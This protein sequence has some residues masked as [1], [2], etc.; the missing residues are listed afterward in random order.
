MKIYALRCRR[1]GRWAAAAGAL[2]LLAGC[3]GGKG[4]AAS[5]TPSP[6]AAATSAAGRVLKV[7]S[8]YA[9][10]QK[11]VDAARPGDMVLIAPGTYH[12]AV[13][14]GDEHPRIVIRGADRNRVILDGRDAKPNGISVYA[15]GVAVENLTVRH[16]QVNGVV[17]AADD[18]Y[19]ANAQFVQGWRGSYLTAYDNGL[20]ELYAF[21]AQ[22]GQFDHVYASGGPDSGIY[23]GRCKPCD[24]VVRDSVAEANHVGYEATNASGGLTVVGNVFRDNRV[25]V[26]INSLNKERGAPQ[27]GSLLVGNLV[28]DNQNAHAP[29]GSTG[30]GAGVVIDGGRGNTVR[31]N[32][33]EGNEGVGVIVL[34]SQDFAAQGNTIERNALRRNGT[35]L[36]LEPGAD[37]S[38]GN[39]FRD[40]DFTTS[41]PRDVEARTSCGRSRALTAAPLKLPTAPPQVD[42]RRVPAPPAQPSMPDAATAPAAPAVGL[43]ETVDLSHVTPPRAGR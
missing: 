18:A 14:V 15:D 35:D 19:A 42:Y 32:R 12:E 43:P 22:H 31:E 27:T 10:I 28:A 21:G 3:G 1:A 11:A 24:A 26:Q 23:V 13:T 41:V 25:G 36:A 9:T 6:S 17:W 40:N 16:Y 2:A 5:A 20:Y 33:I 39:C 30:F 37:G 7:P 8:S 4:G 34:D 29:R 38:A